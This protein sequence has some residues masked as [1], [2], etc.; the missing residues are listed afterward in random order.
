MFEAQEVGGT[1]H[2][3]ARGGSAGFLTALSSNYLAARGEGGV[4]GSIAV[5]YFGD[6]DLSTHLFY[7]FDVRGGDGWVVGPGGTLAL[8]PQ[9]AGSESRYTF[10]EFSRQ[11]L[12]AAHLQVPFSLSIRKASQLAVIGLER[13]GRMRLGPGARLELTPSHQGGTSSHPG[14]RL[15][16][17]EVEI[18]PHAS[19]HADAYSLTVEG[20]VTACNISARRIE[21]Q[22]SLLGIDTW[23][24]R[25][26]ALF[27][28][29]LHVMGKEGISMPFGSIISGHPNLDGDLRIAAPKLHACNILSENR[30]DIKVGNELWLR[31]VVDGSTVA[32]RQPAE[33]VSA[34]LAYAKGNARISAANVRLGAYSSILAGDSLHVETTADLLLS[35]AAAS[36]RSLGNTSLLISGRIAVLSPESDHH[37]SKAHPCMMSS[38]ALVARAAAAFLPCNVL[39]RVGLVLEATTIE[40]SNSIAG[41]EVNIS[42]G[43]I[44]LDTSDI[45]AH[46]LYVTAG[47]PRLRNVRDVPAVTSDMVLRNA[48]FGGSHPGV[49]WEASLECRD[50]VSLENVTVTGC[51]TFGIASESLTMRRCRIE[52]QDLVVRANQSISMTAAQVETAA[53]HLRAVAGSCRINRG[54]TIHASRRISMDCLF[55][56]IGGGRIVSHQVELEAGEA[57]KVIGSHLEAASYVNVKAAQIVLAQQTKVICAERQCEVRMTGAAVD[58]LD[59]VRVQAPDLI[60]QAISIQVQSQCGGRDVQPECSSRLSASGLGSPPSLGQSPGRDF[61]GKTFDRFPYHGGSGGAHGGE[62]GGCCYTGADGAMEAYGNATRPWTAGSGGGMGWEFARGGAGGGRILI[63]A[64]DF[65]LDGYVEADGLPGQSAA[66]GNSEAASGGG[67]AGGSI[68]VRPVASSSF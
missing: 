45:H 43:F 65:L 24:S 38:D 9:Q 50:D 63:K 11:R 52:A 68:Q 39:T 22:G 25:P 49:P 40:L 58:V 31:P 16:A 27:T 44:E 13:V 26:C 56:N 62:S 10:A 12:D 7:N 15:V 36:L 47:S 55:V 17:Q 66:A 1:G 35:R 60:L 42:A 19:L 33:E 57:I 30:L 5:R 64:V 18:A 48:T 23:E 29:E 54:V 8:L 32:G 4:G 41:E 34:C 59:R 37:S 28:G 14:A 61:C 21:V 20:S 67:G 2:V 46:R 51:G 3:T 53:A 6:Q